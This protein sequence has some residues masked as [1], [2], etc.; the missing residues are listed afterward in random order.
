[1]FIMGTIVGEM[2]L[3]EH[4]RK[5]KGWRTIV[6]KAIQN[7]KPIRPAMRSKKSLKKRLDVIGTARFLQEFMHIPISRKDRI[8]KE[9]WIR[10]HT[11]AL[12]KFDYVTMGI[13]VA[14]TEKTKSDETSLCLI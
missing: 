14:T 1:M 13:D 9:H 6:R 11:G 8:V 3:V 12:P 4:L 5:N 2:C 10:Y 7:G